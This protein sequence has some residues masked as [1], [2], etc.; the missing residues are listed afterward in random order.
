MINPRTGKSTVVQ[1]EENGV[2][3]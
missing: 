2:M 3:H 1:S